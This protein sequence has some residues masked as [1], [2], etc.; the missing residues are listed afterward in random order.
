MSA[1]GH[2]E[3]RS[4]VSKI[5]R[6]SQNTH[7]GGHWVTQ[8]RNTVRKNGKNRNPACKIVQLPIPHI[9]ITFIIGFRILMVA[10]R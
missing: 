2:K 7:G 5:E 6:G 3:T 4:E 1:I 10:S 9:L 8:Y